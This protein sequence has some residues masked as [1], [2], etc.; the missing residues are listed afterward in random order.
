[1]TAARAVNS[2]PNRRGT[3]GHRQVLGQPKLPDLRSEINGPENQ[4]ESEADLRGQ[5]RRPAMEQRQPGHHVQ[6]C[7][8]E[9]ERLA[10]RNAGGNR[11]P[12]DGEVPLQQAGEA[13]YKTADTEYPGAEIELGQPVWR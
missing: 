6:H 1:M 5:S 3:D 9:R 7:R 11:L 8:G 13:E 10:K 2:C 12:V 4:V